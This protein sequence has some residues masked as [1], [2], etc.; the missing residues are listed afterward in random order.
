MVITLK[1]NFDL[2]P[3]EQIVMDIFWNENKPLTSVDL[4][5]HLTENCKEWKN[6]YLHN[7]LKGLLDDKKILRITNIV[8]YGRR[9]AKQYEPTMSKEEYAAKVVSSLNF[10]KYSVSKIAYA[11]AKEVSGDD[12]KDIIEELE[13]ILSKLKEK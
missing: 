12:N 5:E 10:N 11:I 4:A 13:E 3:N 7:L 1:K 2:T 6:G 8:Q 9:V